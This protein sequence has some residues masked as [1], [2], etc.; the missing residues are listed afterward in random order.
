MV[1][2]LNPDNL[3]RVLDYSLNPCQI[4]KTAPLMLPGKGYEPRIFYATRLE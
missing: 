1:Y 4:S 2:R 3:S